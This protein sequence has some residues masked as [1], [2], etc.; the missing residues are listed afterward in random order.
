MYLLG[1]C[2]CIL[3]LSRGHVGFEGAK[4]KELLEEKKNE[5]VKP[6]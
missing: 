6:A 5:E 4:A 1:G 2:E 3:G